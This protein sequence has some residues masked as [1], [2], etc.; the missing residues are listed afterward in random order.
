MNADVYQAFTQINPV[1]RVWQP[2]GLNWLLLPHERAQ[3]IQQAA[4]AQR[5]Q[6][7]SRPQAPNAPNT[8]ARLEPAPQSP[9]PPRETSP[10][11]PVPVRNLPTQLP[12]AWA[13]RLQATRRGLIVWTYAALGQDLLGVQSEGLDKRRAFLS[14]LLRDLNHPGGTHTFW[15]VILPESAEPNAPFTPDADSFWAGMA[16]LKARAVVALGDDAVQ[17]LGLPQ[18]LGFMQ[19][20]IYRGALVLS[21]WDVADLLLGEASRSK[22]RS[23][24]DYVRRF[25]SPIIAR[26]YPD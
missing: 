4:P 24:L 22:Y 23:M 1:A 17:A 13:Q 10:Q 20:T 11:R 15:P 25:L 7:Q 26:A 6:F 3:A 5:P 2:R 18:P 9:D 19:Q 12:P 8:S 14:Q 16:R 21:V